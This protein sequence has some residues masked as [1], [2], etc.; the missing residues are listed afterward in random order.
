MADETQFRSTSL[1]CFVTNLI[2]IYSSWGV[3]QNP[4]DYSI[5]DPVERCD[6]DHIGPQI[7][8]LD[9]VLGF[10]ILPSNESSSWND[11]KLNLTG[12]KIG[13][14]ELYNNCFYKNR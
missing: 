3:H 5:V 9:D 6:L 11:V 1:L 2:L 12:K 8:N 10:L 14:P 13:C 7:I 4:I